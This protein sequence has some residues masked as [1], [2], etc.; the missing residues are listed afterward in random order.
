[1]IY[2]GIVKSISE[3][4]NGIS[5]S[6]SGERKE[7]NADAFGVIPYDIAIN[8]VI[9]QAENH[10]L[11]LSLPQRDILRKSILC[12]MLRPALPKMKGM[13]QFLVAAPGNPRI[14]R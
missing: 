6:K 2:E 11:R 14:C 9:E 1:M 12:E 4:A 10:G 8:K 3:L 7:F 5:Y 13:M